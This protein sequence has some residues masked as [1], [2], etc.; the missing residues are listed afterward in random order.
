MGR[1]VTPAVGGHCL[2]SPPLPAPGGCPG[3]RSGIWIFVFNIISA[4]AFPPPA[5]HLLLQQLPRQCTSPGTEQAFPGPSPSPF[6]SGREGTSPRWRESGLG[7]THCPTP[8]P[9]PSLGHSPTLPPSPADSGNPKEEREGETRHTQKWK[10][11]GAERHCKPGGGEGLGVKEGR[12]DRGGERKVGEINRTRNGHFTKPQ[13][14]FPPNPTKIK[15]PLK[16]I[17]QPGP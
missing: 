13:P 12:R 11:D 2:L 9:T 1:Q 14:S 8:P 6:P 17:N 3:C 15:L 4:C 16:K 10:E 7:V 5:P